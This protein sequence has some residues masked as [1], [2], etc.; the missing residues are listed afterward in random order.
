MDT[1]VTILQSDL[2]A[3]QVIKSLNLDKLP[4]YGGRPVN[5][6]VDNLAPDPLQADSA[7]TSGL[8]GGFKG[9]L[10]VALKPNNTDRRNPLR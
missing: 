5:G 7:R 9:G 3:L 10:R 1:E 8:L 4:E 2:L 6:P